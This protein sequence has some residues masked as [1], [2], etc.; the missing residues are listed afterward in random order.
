LTFRFLSLKKNKKKYTNYS[1]D[2]GVKTI[3]I[4]SFEKQSNQELFF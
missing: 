4:D 1:G 3:T 2:Y